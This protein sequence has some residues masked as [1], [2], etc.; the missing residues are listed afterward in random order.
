MKLWL[1]GIPGV[2]VPPDKI[3][4]AALE[5]LGPVDGGLP[6]YRSGGLAVR[7]RL[8]YPFPGD[9]HEPSDEQRRTFERSR[10]TTLVWYYCSA[11]E[12][13]LWNGSEDIASV[14]VAKEYGRAAGVEVIV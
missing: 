9:G 6:V 10:A 14:H 13:V 8:V 3:A 7:V 4:A 2:H 12:G 11:L 1:P 5:V